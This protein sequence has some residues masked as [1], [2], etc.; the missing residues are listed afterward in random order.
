MRERALRLT[1]AESGQGTAQ[2]ILIRDVAAK[3]F[4]VAAAKMGVELS[5]VESAKLVRDWRGANPQI[6]EYWRLL[7]EAPGR[8]RSAG[9]PIPLRTFQCPRSQRKSANAGAGL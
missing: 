6:V 1:H 5:E 9:R 3:G 8:P 4:L 7:D 2:T